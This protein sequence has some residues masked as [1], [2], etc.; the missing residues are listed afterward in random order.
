VILLPF[1]SSYYR[2]NRRRVLVCVALRGSAMLLLLAIAP[3]ALVGYI[4]AYLLLLITLRMMDMHQHTYDIRENLAAGRIATAFDRGYEQQHTFSN[5][6]GDSALL[7]GLVL[8]FG[9]HNAH[10]AQPIQPWYRLP[11]L[12]RQ[13]GAAWTGQAVAFASVLKNYSRWR[14]E[15]IMAGAESGTLSEA[16]RQRAQ[17]IGIYGVSFLT[18]V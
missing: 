1:H 9:Y 3:L 18:A 8:N 14:V 7:N 12:D 13:A 2:H 16:A 11:E 15:R 17:A 6:L 5:R 4:F 10:H